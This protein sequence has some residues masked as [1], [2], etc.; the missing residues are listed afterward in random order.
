MKT[1]KA[2][3][4]KTAIFGY[5][6]GHHLALEIYEKSSINEADIEKRLRAAGGAHQPSDMQ[7]PG[8]GHAVTFGADLTGVST[9]STPRL[10]ASVSSSSLLPSSGSSPRIA[11][12]MPVPVLVPKHTQSAPIVGAAAAAAETAAATAI[13]AATAA[14]AIITATTAAVAA[15]TIAAEKAKGLAAAGEPVSAADVSALSL[16]LETIA[17]SLRSAA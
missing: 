8:G 1:A 7:F 11:A 9:P 13:A 6:K 17:R 16:E 15:I 5:F 10:T 2:I 3:P 14:A 12:S 4:T